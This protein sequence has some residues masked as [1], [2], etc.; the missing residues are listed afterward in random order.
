MS[1]FWSSDGGSDG[2]NSPSPR[3]SP[4]HRGSPQHQPVEIPSASERSESV[5]TDRTV[6]TA[7]DSPEEEISDEEIVEEIPE[8]SRSTRSKSKHKKK[9]SSNKHVDMTPPDKLLKKAEKRASHYAKKNKSS[10]AIKEY[11]RC[12]ALSRI[13]YGDEHWRYVKSYAD[14]ASAYLDLKGYPTQAQYHCENAKKM[15]SQV[16]TSEGNRHQISEVQVNIHYTLGRALMA[17]KKFNEAEQALLRAE[18]IAKERS[19]NPAV[20]EDNVEK[21]QIKLYLAIARLS[22]KCQK[23]AMAIA[24]FDKALHVL[25]NRY[26][27]D[28]IE[29]VP[30]YQGLGKVEQSKGS[31][32]DHDRAIEY[33]TQAHAITSASKEHEGTSM[34][35]D[36]ARALATA[37]SNV[38]ASEAEI[39]AESYLNEALII[40][41]KVHGPH[42]IKTLEVQEELARLMIRTSRTSEGI[43]LLKSTMPDR[44]EV[45]GELSPQVAD[46]WKLIG[47]VHLSLGESEKALRALK[48]CHSIECDVYGK[49]HK[50]SK[51]TERTLDIL[52][53]NP[54]LA[55]KQ[56]KS[57]A[58]EARPRFNGSSKVAAY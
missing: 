30:V 3:T 1:D 44:K 37:Y 50:K 17:H 49:N 46:T 35:A 38:G 5:L 26:G 42:H 43:E 52:L 58:L 57:N 36:T 33:F 24:Y 39:S 56:K 22:G 6:D 11:I 21:W 4:K 16:E 7:R 13:V 34:V 32:A 9:S 31:N 53:A 28:S 45:Y 20:S 47:N 40:Y 12:T 51:D 15:M 48:K 2:E 25:D 10:H 19:K 41:Q 27:P 14:L 29:L 18:K 55:S 8:T 23:H 54:N